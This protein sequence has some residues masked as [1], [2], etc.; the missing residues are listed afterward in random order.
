MEENKLPDI[1][2]IYEMLNWENTP[3]LQQE[4]IR[5]AREI[6][7]LSLLIMPYA[8]VSVWENCANIICEKSDVELEPYLDKLL[9]WLMDLNWS[10]ALTIAERLKIFS[11]EKLKIALEKAIIKSNQMTNDERLKWLDYLSELLDNKVL[12]S[13]LPE[14]IIILLKK[15]Y[16]NW[17]N[18]CSE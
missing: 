1:N 11:G 15:H 9:E 3:E 10:G 7:D 5:L 13:N 6:K 8:S 12:V 2:K 14:E 18:W 16:H 4:G 17:G